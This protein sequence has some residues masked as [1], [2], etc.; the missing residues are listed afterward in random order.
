MSQKHTL[1]NI[2]VH[3]P[4]LD[5]WDIDL[6]SFTRIIILLFLMHMD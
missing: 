2:P 4:L 1:L 3:I 5:P 6:Y